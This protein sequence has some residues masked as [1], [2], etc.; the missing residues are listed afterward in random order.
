MTGTEQTFRITYHD[1]NLSQLVPAGAGPPTAEAC[2]ILAYVSRMSR[3]FRSAE[4]IRDEV[5]RLLSEKGHI[6]LTVPLPIRADPTDSNNGANWDMPHL[7]RGTYGFQ[8]EI[9]LVLL[10]VK[11]RWDLEMV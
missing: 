9:G 3:E 11:N 6:Q 8:I 1:V 4:A 5:A 2:V 10:A 7:F